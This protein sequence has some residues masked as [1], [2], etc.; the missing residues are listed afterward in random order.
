MTLKD[1]NR[2]I[3]K[4]NMSIARKIFYQ[5]TSWIIFFLGT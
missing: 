1:L 4:G 3:H 2:T 5:E